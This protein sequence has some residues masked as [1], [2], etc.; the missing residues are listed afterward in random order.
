MVHHISLKSTLAISV[1]SLVLKGKAS[2]HLLKES[3]TRSIYLWPSVVLVSGPR[4]SMWI[5]ENLSS[6]G[7]GV[8]G[9]GA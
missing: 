7:I 1:E 6:I 8:S 2:G 9:A 3:T 5:R 4:M